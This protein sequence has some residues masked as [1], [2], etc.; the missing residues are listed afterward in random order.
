MS[1]SAVTL[2]RRRWHKR[3]QEC[4]PKHCKPQCTP[5]CSSSERCILDV[6]KECG[7]CPV[8]QCVSL[9]ALGVSSTQVGGSSNEPQPSSSG[10]DRN[11]L[12]VGLT[13]G[14]VLGAVVVVTIAGFVY[15]KRKRRTQQ[16]QIE[17]EER[18]PTIPIKPLGPPPAP[19]VLPATTTA[20]MNNSFWPKL[21]RHPH[22]HLCSWAT[23]CKSLDLQRLPAL[24]HP[25]RQPPF[26]SP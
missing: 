24:L 8:S 10:G 19:A 12:I 11:G 3:G 16:R 26:V 13:T 21:H 9:S 14:L 18:V 2:A 6:M 20:M 15:F 4:Q 23:H 17:L 7:Q 25:P 1:P 22:N 5:S